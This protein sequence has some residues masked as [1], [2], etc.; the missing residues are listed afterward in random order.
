MTE[1]A[2]PL[3]DLTLELFSSRNR[4]ANEDWLAADISWELLKAIGADHETQTDQLS[5][6][7]ALY[8]RTMQ[9]FHKVHSVRWRVKSPEHLM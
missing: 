6:T 7:A 4:V 8:A 2:A 9:R 5:D 1:E 3:N